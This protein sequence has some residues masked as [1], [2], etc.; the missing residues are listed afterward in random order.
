[1]LYFVSQRFKMPQK[2]SITTL[3]DAVHFM[4]TFDTKT[5]C[6]LLNGKLQL[7]TQKYCRVIKMDSAV[8]AYN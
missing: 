6:Y 5:E 3:F 2:C 1:M 8:W 4:Q 7:N